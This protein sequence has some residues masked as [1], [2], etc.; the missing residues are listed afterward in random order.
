MSAEHHRTPPPST[1]AVLPYASSPGTAP[2]RDRCG[3]ALVLGAI[4]TATAAA[5][6]IPGVLADPPLRVAL[7]FAVVVALLLCLIGLAHAGLAIK[8][9]HR[10]RWAWTALALNAL[11]FAMIAV[12]FW[13]KH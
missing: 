10:S 1:P 13:T 12:R 9:H 8:R 2:P 11:P 6:W 3:D 7:T 5:A 4:G